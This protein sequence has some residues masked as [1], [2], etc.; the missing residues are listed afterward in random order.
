M[1]SKLWCPWEPP[2]ET[3]THVYKEYF[4]EGNKD[5]FIKGHAVVKVVDAKHRIIFE[6]ESMIASEEIVK[7][8][9]K[10]YPQ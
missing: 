3:I 4:I 5:I 8:M 1:K 9:N 6:G 10:K 7:A 2:L